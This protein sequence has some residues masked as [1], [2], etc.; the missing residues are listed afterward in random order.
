[1]LFDTYTEFCFTIVFT[2]PQN[3]FVFSKGKVY[4]KLTYGKRNL[5]TFFKDLDYPYV[6]L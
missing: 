4:L 2:Q 1:M 3:V 6:S 5:F